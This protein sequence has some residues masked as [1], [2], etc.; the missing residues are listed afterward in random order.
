MA[1]VIAA[2]ALFAAA[3]GGDEGDSGSGDAQAFKIGYSADL[4]GGFASYD[5]PIRDGAQTAIDEI[6]A[7]G[8]INGMM[9][10]M[11]VKDNKNDKVLAVQTTQE[12]IDEGIQYLIGTTSDHVVAANRLAQEQSIP[13]STGDGTA[14]NLVGDIGE[15]AFQYIMGDNIQ[16][17]A[18]AE[19]SYNK[20]GYRSAFLLRCADIPY[21]ANLPYYFRDSFERL[22]GKTVG[23]AEYKYEAGDFA[24][25]VTKIK[26]AKPA[27]DVI[28]TPM[29][30]P[31]TPVFLKQLRAA[32]V[33]TP[34]V[35]TDGN[36]TP[37]I[38]SA[39]AKALDG[40]KFTTFAY[41]SEGTSLAKFYDT[42]K[43]KYGKEPDTVIY[44]NG[45]DEIYILKAALEKT[46]GEGGQALRDALANVTDLDLATT[47]GYAMDPATRRAKRGVAL[48]EMKGAAFS[49]VEDL[50][51]PDFVPDPI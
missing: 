16:G 38:L 4:T 15:Y 43:A 35:S 27:P 8:G 6:N 40:L 18:L 31:D 44:A 32:G 23:V 22:G 39:G 41:P 2:S 30:L 33:T 51:F 1:V 9:L 36:D 45:Y 46:G 13:S 50:P 28:F 11:V 29:F 20:M 21:T 3:C 34:V 7:A 19:Y 47:D 26:N 42:Y 25:Q 10:E 49:F 48:V 24:A 12:L 17:A 14:P 5:V 37:D